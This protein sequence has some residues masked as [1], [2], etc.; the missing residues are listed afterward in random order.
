MTVDMTPGTDKSEE[1]GWATVI[2]EPKVTAV[3]ADVWERVPV[4]PGKT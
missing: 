4:S 1:R 2:G 3:F